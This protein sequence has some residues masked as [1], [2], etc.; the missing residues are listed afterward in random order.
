MTVFRQ[1]STLRLTLSLRSLRLRQTQS[2]WTPQSWRLYRQHL[3]VERSVETLS[4]CLFNVKTYDRYVMYLT[5][6]F[7]SK[8]KFFLW[9]IPAKLI[10]CSDLDSVQPRLQHNGRFHELCVITSLDTCVNVSV[11]SPGRG[12]SDC[13]LLS[14]PRPL[15]AACCPDWGCPRCPAAPCPASPVMTSILS[16]LWLVNATY[17]G[18]W[19]AAATHQDNP[20]WH[21][22]LSLH[23]PLQQ[24]LRV[25]LAEPKLRVYSTLLNINDKRVLT[26][27]EQT[28]NYSTLLNIV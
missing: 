16:G 22:R 19:L 8:N 23:L 9:I 1:K 18:L 2:R 27:I 15:E 26:D 3:E 21:I 13:G 14:P 11:D 5:S 28:D 24:V 7:G 17:P 12:Q 6:A 25:Q 20:L 10:S 4:I